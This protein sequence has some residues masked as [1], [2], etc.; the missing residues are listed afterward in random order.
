MAFSG[1][2][3]SHKSS[4]WKERKEKPAGNA[5]LCVSKERIMS[6]KTLSLIA[7][8]LAELLKDFMDKLSGSDATT[9]LRAFRR[10]LKKENPWSKFTARWVVTLGVQNSPEAYSKALGK[11]VSAHT[12]DVLE[13]ITCSKKRVKIHLVDASFGD[14][15]LTEGG[16]L[17]EFHAAVKQYGGTKCPA[18]VGPALRLLYKNQLLGER[19]MILMDAI[20]DSHGESNLFCLNLRRDGVWL[21]TDDGKPNNRFDP[22]LRIVFA[23][24]AQ[25]F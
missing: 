3:K 5:V 16:T 24:S 18:E 6:R 21:T 22:N 8:Q 14:I 17:A 2:G 20:I 9:W 19:I 13:K 23:I 4:V 12:L 11:N 7:P 25:E 15:G 10:F 1:H